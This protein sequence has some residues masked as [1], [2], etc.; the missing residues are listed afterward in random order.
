MIDRLMI[1][2]LKHSLIMFDSLHTASISLD[3]QPT[4]RDRGGPVPDLPLLLVLADGPE[5][6]RAGPGGDPLV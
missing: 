2:R 1:D 3:G 6:P 4:S 5:D